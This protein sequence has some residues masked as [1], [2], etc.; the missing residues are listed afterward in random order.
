MIR[1]NLLI[2]NNLNKSFLFIFFKYHAGTIKNIREAAN[3]LKGTKFFRPVAI[4]LDTKGPEIRT[5]LIKGSATAEVELVRGKTVEIVIDPAF[6]ENCDET[7][8][9]VDYPNILK[10]VKP[11]NKIFVDDG[12]I[13]LV[14]KEINE[15]KIV[16]EVENGGLLGSK[17]GVNLPGLPV[18][19]PA[20]SEKDRADLKFGVEQNVDMIFASFIRDAEGVKEVRRALGDQGRHILIVSKIE[21]HQGV[22]K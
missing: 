1:F 10:I 18:D 16:T 22:H 11:G 5:G 4:A 7:T 19:L 20:V 15:N 21:N 8:L 13:S 6:Y 12:L 14:A 3:S 2:I 9:W 17:K